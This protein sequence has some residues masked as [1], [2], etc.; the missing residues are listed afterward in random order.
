MKT[1]TESEV[2]KD[3]NPADVCPACG[4]RMTPSNPR[5]CDTGQFVWLFDDIGPGVAKVC[6]WQEVAAKP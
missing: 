5:R 3:N 1:E 4:G 2:K 6:D